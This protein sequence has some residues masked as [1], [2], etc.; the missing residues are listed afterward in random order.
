MNSFMNSVI[1]S[2]DTRCGSGNGNSGSGIS[3]LSETQ[4]ATNLLS[5]TEIQRVL[6]EFL[7]VSSKVKADRKCG[8]WVNPGTGNIERQFPNRN[9]HPVNA[10]VTQTQ[11]P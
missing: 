11:N 7:I 10:E 6:E 8:R 5:Q 4:C 9:R 2:S 3:G 1:S